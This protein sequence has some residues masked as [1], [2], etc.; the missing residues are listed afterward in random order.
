[1]RRGAVVV[2]LWLVLV[3]VAFGVQ[4]SN[5]AENYQFEVGLKLSKILDRQMVF[6]FTASGCPHCQDFKEEVL[7]DPSVK[8]FL[9]KHFVFSLISLDSTF[10]LE[11][12]EKGTITN[13]ELASSLGVEYTP[14]TYVFYPP[15]P[16][17]EGN[18]VVKIPGA[19]SG[20]EKMINLLERVLSEA[21]EG[22]GEG[23]AGNR[24]YNYRN[25]VKEITEDDFVFL[26]EK[27][28]G[29]IPVIPERVDPSELT[30]VKEVLLSFYPED[31]EGY[32]DAILS[33]TQVEK[34]YVLKP[35]T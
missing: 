22:E 8:E 23:V 15:D 11:L 30:D 7:S 14:T 29:E 19:V 32:T 25:A 9:G 27:Y 10:D 4:G 20:P 17:L 28:Q 18:D 3:L 33:E 13:M 21:K 24:P 26:R 16:G 6:S 5:V 31:L 2:L 35:A 12:P 1:M 34:I